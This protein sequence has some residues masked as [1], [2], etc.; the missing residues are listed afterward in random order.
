LI[1]AYGLVAR[2]AHRAVELAREQGIKVGLLRPQTLYPFPYKPIAD[3][4]KQVNGVLV[5]EM[6]AGQMVED[7]RLGV[8]GRVPVEFH[9]RM[10]GIIP[11]PEE[12]VKALEKLIHK[13]AE[14]T[15]EAF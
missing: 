15:A 2:I 1:V 8:E 5:V 14:Q 9:G 4:A 13:N 3:L 10:G 12:I 6:N 7:V 11:S